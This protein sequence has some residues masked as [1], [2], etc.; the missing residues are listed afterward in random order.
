MNI[1]TPFAYVLCMFLASLVVSCD[2]LL[3]EAPEPGES[4]DEPMEGLTKQ[5]LAAFSRG[6][7]GFGKIFSVKEGLGPIFNQPACE[8]CHPRDG[9]GNPRTNLIRF[10]RYENGVFDLL[11]DAGGPQLQNR[12]IPGV[13][14]E[15]LPAHANAVSH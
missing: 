8:S 7:E 4:F 2:A 6:D 3:T 5:Q 12:S 9:K 14:P 15:T 13:P 11:L 1:R 10:G